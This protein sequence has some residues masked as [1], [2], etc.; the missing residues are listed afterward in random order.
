MMI[1]H[2][3]SGYLLATFLYPTCTA[4]GIARPA[5]FAAAIIGALAPDLDMLYFHFADHRQHHHHTYWPHFPSV[6]LALLALTAAW[7]AISTT[8]RH[9]ALAFVFCLG[10][11]THLLLDS[12]VGD[13]WWFAPLIDRPFSL[14]SVPA[15]YHPWWLN[16]IFHW[17]FALELA[18]WLW[19]LLLYRR[20]TR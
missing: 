16:F 9:A 8:S 1:G 18:L 2:A 13:I 14:F 17:S 19:A 6:W 11:F 3:P 5:F 4:R 7:S 15:R 12:I 10:G 20:R